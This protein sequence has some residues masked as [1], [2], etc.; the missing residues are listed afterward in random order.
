MS[1]AWPFQETAEG[2]GPTRPPDVDGFVERN[3][4]DQTDAVVTRIGLSGF[5][6]VLV[7]QDGS[8]DKWV[9]PT[10]QDAIEAAQAAG[11]GNVHK[12]SY[13]EE[14]RVRMNAYQR[15][16]ADFDSGAYQEQGRVGPVKPYPENRPRVDRAAGHRDDR[17]RDAT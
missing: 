14:V 12:D 17:K 16:R 15:P 13:P 9:Y 8:W 5:Q 4:A 1:R 3:P 10:K 2:T 6:L 11:I 7:A